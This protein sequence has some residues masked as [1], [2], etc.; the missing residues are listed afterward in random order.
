[1]P[2]YGHPDVT[3]GRDSE[4]AFLRQTVERSL[5]GSGAAIA[6]EGEPGIG[7]SHLL[8]GLVSD[9]RGRD[10]V[11]V[12][13]SGHLSDMFE[14]FVALSHL[15]V[16]SETAPH[17]VMALDADPRTR[18]AAFNGY[19][20][21]LSRRPALV[22]IDDL[23]WV[24]EASLQVISK[25]IENAIGLGITFVCALRTGASETDPSRSGALRSI[26]RSCTRLQLEGL[27]EHACAE[28]AAT[29]GD[30]AV[31]QHDIRTIHRITDGNPL[32][33]LEYLRL[34]RL[35]DSPSLRHAPPEVS[36]VIESRLRLATLDLRVLVALALL[37]G[38]A[39]DDDLVV[40]A[41]AFGLTPEATRRT[42]VVA[43]SALLIRRRSG[44]DVEFVHP[45]YTTCASAFPESH[46]PQLRTA[47][48]S[49]LEREGRVAEAFEL[50]DAGTVDRF[51]D[52]ACR[53]AGLTLGNASFDGDTTLSARAADFLL[54]RVDP[55]SRE[56]VRA[57]LARA[58][59]L[60]ATGQRDE[61]WQLAERA[62]T[63]SQ[64]LGLHTEQAHALLTMSRIAEFMPDTQG[65]AHNLGL[66]ELDQ[67]PP[68]LRVRVLATSA[69]VVLSTPTAVTDGFQPVGS[70][71]R[72]AGIEISNS[73]SRSAW[74]W[75]TNAQ[76]ARA[77]ANR[78]LDML[79]ESPV[80]SAI[81][82]EVLNAWREVHRSPDFLAQ[83][84]G[85][86]ERAIGFS[87][88]SA[89]IDSRLTRSIDLYED[90]SRHRATAELTVASEAAKRFGDARGQ[91]RV[92]LRWAADALA[93]GDI[94]TAWD[95]AATALSV[96]EQAGE[97]G[98][99]PAL[100]AQ[101]CA[102]AIERIFPAE[103]LWIFSVDPAFTA[104]GPSRA[105]A[106]LASV[107]AGDLDRATELL[108]QSFAVFDDTDRESSW[109]LTLC[110][111]AEVASM[112]DH[113]DFAKRVIT[114]LEPFAEL[115]VI[116][117]IG[118]L[119]RGPVARSLGLAHRTVGDI[120]SA[121]GLLIRARRT[122][123]DNGEHLWRLAALVDIAETLAPTGSPRLP[124][125]VQMTDIDDAHERGLDWRAGRGRRALEAAG[126]V[127][128]DTLTLS[129]RQ[130]AILRE[131]ARGLT[132]ADIGRVLQYSHSTVRQE[133]MAIYRLLEVDG[134]EA[135][136]AA[137]RERFVI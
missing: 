122:A 47:V 69:P 49:F 29:V 135:A 123:E 27:S 40:I 43:E 51:P 66:L 133:S 102:V 126:R 78:A 22:V 106:A 28:L 38:V 125:L 81:S 24:D 25:S 83:R 31:D 33:T 137:A 94:E 118:T 86:S 111:L 53:L 119:A 131:M 37:G 48:I 92:A 85:L 70:A 19:L 77:L 76:P 121:V 20:S 75:S 35:S 44:R 32:F 91:W 124:Q 134:R 114:A 62:A 67:L 1:M 45:L 127:V 17:E 71:F 7:K 6:I 105:L 73:G 107:S 23:Q 101:Q 108:E 30:V 136:V 11:V 9:A 61:G 4:L 5:T 96:G 15:P 115:N 42:T 129:D 55:S 110:T 65:Y 72:E 10:I 90:G 63:T 99:V 113:V 116:D 41:E 64:T 12:H 68:A 97:P 21:Q 50:C 132:I 82:V 128:K 88:P 57:A 117:G 79:A 58:R 120:E 46:D 36:R 89:A 98:R 109:L 18:F 34:V 100:A 13:L 130:V 8:R 16:L 95:R 59:H 14:P 112:V 26:L 104:H 87:D 2:A 60:I 3:V 54:S 103:H 93:T 39:T 56:W 52:L 80:P 84:L 74:A